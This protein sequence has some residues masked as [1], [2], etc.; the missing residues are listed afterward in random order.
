MLSRCQHRATGWGVKRMAVSMCLVGLDMGTTG[1]KACAFDL[2]GGLLGSAYREYPLLHPQAGW[3]ELCPRTVVSSMKEVLAELGAGIEAPIGAISVSSQGQAVLPIDREGRPLYNIIV[4]M[5]GRT[6]PQHRWWMENVDSSRVYERTGL[7]FASIYTVNKIMW[8]R[9]NNPELYERAWK[10]C[11]VQDYIIHELCGELLMDYSLAGRTM[12]LNPR[13]KRWD[14]WVLGLAGIDLGKLSRLAP[15]TTVAG[16]LR[17]GLARELGL[18]PDIRI[19]VGGHDQACGAIGAGVVRPGMAMN[20]LGTVDALVAVLPGFSESSVMLK[21]NY[22]CY[23]HALHDHYITMAIN[24]NSGLLL[25][26]FKNTVCSEEKA[27][28]KANGLDPYDYIIGKIPDG[29]SDLYVLPHLEGAGTPIM[30]P[31][32]TGA[33]VGLRLTTGKDELCRA[34]L[35]SLTYDMRQNVEALEAAGNRL[36]EIRAVGGGAKS[37]K[38]LQIKANIFGKPVVALEV[39]EAASLGAAI[40]GGVGIG[41][42][43]DG[44][45]AAG[46]MVRTGRTFEPDASVK[47][48]YDERY[49]GYLTLYPSLKELSHSIRR[50]GE[51]GI[52]QK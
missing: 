6:T 34:V 19:V 4:T 43:P 12:M 23:P 41:L 11:C 39:T 48:A 35:E 10:F 40:L 2:K 27:Y 29:I 17:P 30:D 22:P 38:W 5:D 20:A 7:S 21:N 16:T 45:S 37:Q 24:T 50:R 28:A 8:H 52:G 13:E 46:E 15:S 1:V 26:W 51:P 47:Q 32:A 42:F 3:S 18:S 36:D 14:E 9:Q 31:E 33:I 25:K 44:E 49:A